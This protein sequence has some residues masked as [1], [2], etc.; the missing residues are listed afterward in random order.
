MRAWI[1]PRRTVSETSSTA[2]KPWN[3][4]VRRRVS[5]MTSVTRAW[6]L[7]CPQ[8]GLLHERQ[9]PGAEELEVRQVVVE[10]HLDAV[11]AGAVQAHEGIHD[12]LGRA[13]H[14]DVAADDPVV[15]RGR[16][17]GRLVAAHEGGV[18]VVGG[19]RVLMLQDRA[20]LIP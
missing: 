18:E 15:A 4:L 2:T 3:S 5:R 7:P 8:A 12:L 1:V 16:F 13:H 6:S 9:D 20:V 11:A 10:V 14:V 17:P 19:H